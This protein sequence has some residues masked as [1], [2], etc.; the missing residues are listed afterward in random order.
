M[1]GKQPWAAQLEARAKYD[2]WASVKGM[3]KEEAMQHYIEL[4][5]DPDVWENDPTLQQ[6]PGPQWM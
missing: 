2:A 1:Q 5:E 3:S 4:L 6:Y